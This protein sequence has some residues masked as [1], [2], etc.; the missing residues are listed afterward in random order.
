MNTAVKKYLLSWVALVAFVALQAGMTE[1]PV[2]GLSRTVA[3]LLA[4][5]MVA[6]VAALLMTWHRA[7]ALAALFALSGIF[8]TV[9]LF[10]MGTSSEPVWPTLPTQQNQVQ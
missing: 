1:L 2:D 4:W 8:W 7:P 3:L 6:L 9:V 5:L 10:G